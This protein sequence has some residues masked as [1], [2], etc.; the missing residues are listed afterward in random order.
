L[1]TAT[2]HVVTLHCG[3]LDDFQFLVHRT[4]ETVS[5]QS[6]V[7]ITLMTLAP[8]FYGGT[9]KELNGYL[10]HDVDGN[11]FLVSGPHSGVTALHAMFHP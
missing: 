5:L 8:A 9:L 3:G 6:N 4:P 11:I 2:G 10:A 1:A 7:A